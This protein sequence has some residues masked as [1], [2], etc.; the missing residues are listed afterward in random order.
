MLKFIRIPQLCKTWAALSIE[1]TPLEG[2][3]EAPRQQIWS[4]D[5]HKIS[6]KHS[7]ALG[8]GK[9]EFPK[10]QQHHRHL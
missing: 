4:Q 3:Q 1:E 7:G 10:H 9:Q 6:T 8:G 2:K 5:D